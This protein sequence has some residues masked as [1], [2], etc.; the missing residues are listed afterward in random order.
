MSLISAGS[1]SLDST[2]NAFLAVHFLLFMV[3][4]LITLLCNFVQGDDSQSRLPKKF[5]LCSSTL[6]SVYQFVC[7]ML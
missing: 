4:Y 6:F 1:I 2:F 3:F 5:T 7:T